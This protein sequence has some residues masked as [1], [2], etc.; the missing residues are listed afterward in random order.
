MSDQTLGVIPLPTKLWGVGDSVYVQYSPHL[1]AALGET[2]SYE[3]N[4]GLAQA[5][6]NLDI[7]Q[8]ANGGDSRR[9]LSFFEKALG[10]PAF[11]ADVIL[12][13]CGLHDIKQPPGGGPVQVPIQEYQANLKRMIALADKRAIRLV[14]VTTT[15]VCEVK[16][17]LPGYPI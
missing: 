1:K 12:F 14:W 10:Q 4:E 15:P 2:F 16:H 6:T 7:P 5:M 11:E 17:N 13:N 8:G 3:L 9:C